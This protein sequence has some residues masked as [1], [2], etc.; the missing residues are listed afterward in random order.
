MGVKIIHLLALKLKTVG[1][2]PLNI[3]F[4]E[5]TG[6]SFYQE[7]GLGQA[8]REVRLHYTNLHIYLLILWS[9]YEVT[10]GGEIWLSS[11]RD[12]LA[13]HKSSNLFIY[14]YY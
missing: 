7:A 5:N 11:Q 6:F 10:A 12:A 9:I 2:H 4:R 8:V 3:K 1:C 14:F 13:V